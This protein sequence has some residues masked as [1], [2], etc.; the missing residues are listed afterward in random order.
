EGSA[1][2]EGFAPAADTLYAI[3]QAAEAA[4]GEEV[5]VAI[6]AGPS[7]NPC[8]YPIAG[9]T[10]E[11]DAEYVLDSYNVG[12]LEGG[13]YDVDGIWTG[14][15]DPFDPFVPGPTVHDLF[16]DQAD[17]AGGRHRFDLGVTP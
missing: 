15:L 5:T 11:D 3:P 16:G 17:I 2:P 14:L 1:I 13:M 10:V 9:L 6:V 4:V 12:D 7:T 8:R